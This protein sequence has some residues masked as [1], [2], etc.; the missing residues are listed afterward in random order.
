MSLGVAT[1][2]MHL[3]KAFEFDHDYFYLRVHVFTRGVLNPVWVTFLILSFPKQG[4]LRLHLLNKTLFWYFISFFF[5]FRVVI[6]LFQKR[7]IM[8]KNIIIWTCY[9]NIWWNR[10]LTTSQA[11]F[12]YFAWRLWY[13]LER[14]IEIR[15]EKEWEKFMQSV[16]SSIKI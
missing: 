16:I 2:N 4:R 6:T 13:F 14:K 5:W 3:L 10:G 7:L 15:R 9:L 11:L 8:N 1:G 12:F